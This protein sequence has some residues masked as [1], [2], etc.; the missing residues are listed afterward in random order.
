MS[1]QRDRSGQ[2][3]PGWVDVDAVI[4]APDIEFGETLADK[5]GKDESPISFVQK[6]FR[7]SPLSEQ[8]KTKADSESVSIS[9]SKDPSTIILNANDSGS[10]NFLGDI[11]TDCGSLSSKKSGASSRI[12]LHSV[13][14]D[15]DE[16]QSEIAV[17][18]ATPSILGEKEDKENEDVSEFDDEALMVPSFVLPEHYSTIPQKAAPIDPIGIGPDAGPKRELPIT[19]DVERQEPDDNQS[20]ASEGDLRGLAVAPEAVPFDEHS[21]IS[22]DSSFFMGVM[23]TSVRSDDN[24]QEPISKKIYTMDTTL[25]T[26]TSNAR[27]DLSKVDGSEKNERT[28][29]MRKDRMRRFGIAIV[30]IL[31]ALILLVLGTIFAINDTKGN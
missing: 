9:S 1:E 29:E 24:G 20:E 7:Q 6:R 26:S 18:A 21:A 27:N 10:V 16:E 31:L 15:G 30:L 8:G 13:I 4:Q 22:Q 14:S 12:Q 17:V 2:E 25:M 28:E 19:Y 5:K 11:D 3:P 23:S